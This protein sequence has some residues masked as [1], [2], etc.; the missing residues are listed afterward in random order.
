MSIFNNPILVTLSDS[1][2]FVQLQTYDEK[3]GQSQ[4]FYLTKST[5]ENLLGD[6]TEVNF[7]ECDLLNY[8][9]VAHV[10]N[11]IRFSVCWLHGNYADDVCGYRQTFFVPVDKIAAVLNGKRV[12]HL[13]H[14]PVHQET[15]NI[16]FTKTAHADIA[17]AKNNKLKFHAIRRVFRDNFNYGR[18]EHLVIQRD[19][20][21]H[22]FYFFS[23]I[24]QYEGGIALHEAEVKGKDGKPHRKVFYGIHT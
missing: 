17:A 10:D 14:Q 16:F 21:V 3:H 20:F 24:S 5:F 23:T 19:E 8:C 9:T 4:R 22:G 15:A 6:D 1:D 7:T 18:N 13:S 2:P 11:S 12:K